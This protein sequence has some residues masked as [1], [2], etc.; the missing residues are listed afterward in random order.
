MSYFYIFVQTQQLL[1]QLML[2]P[3]FLE[4]QSVVQLFCSAHIQ[5]SLSCQLCPI[6]KFTLTLTLR[7][8]RQILLCY[9]VYQQHSCD[10][11]LKN[12]KIDVNWHRIKLNN[13][14]HC[15]C[16]HNR[17][18]ETFDYLGHFSQAAFISRQIVPLPFLS[19]LKT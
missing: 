11:S 15:S 1:E 6:L 17:Q 4:G 12:V 18:A 3:V 2:T 5:E 9:H 14:F 19:L 7:V 8:P 16:T 13:F 10:S